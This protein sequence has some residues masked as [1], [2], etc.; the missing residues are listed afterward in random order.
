M[1]AEQV[2][3]HCCRVGTGLI[4]VCVVPETVHPVRVA[5]QVVLHAEALTD[6]PI[7]VVPAVKAAHITLQSLAKAVEVHDI[8]VVKLAENDTDDGDGFEVLL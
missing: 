1:H 6:T 7:L 8:D 5:K 3:A 2:Y 4:D